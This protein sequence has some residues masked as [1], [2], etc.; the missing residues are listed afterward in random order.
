MSRARSKV[1]LVA[2]RGAFQ[3]LPMDPDSLRAASLFKVLFQIL[4]QVDLTKVYS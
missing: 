3:G 4:P 2:S 1:I